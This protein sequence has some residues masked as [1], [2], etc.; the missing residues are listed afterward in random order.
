ME[1]H[2]AN[3]GKDPNLRAADLSGSILRLEWLELEWLGF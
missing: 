2:F 1:E 3:R